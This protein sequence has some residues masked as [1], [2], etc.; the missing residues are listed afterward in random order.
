MKNK[1]TWKLM[2]TMSCIW[3]EN[4]IILRFLNFIQIIIFFVLLLD[5]CRKYIQ[6]K[7][8]NSL[9]KSWIL[10][11]NNK[12]FIRFWN[13]SNIFRQFRNNKIAK[14]FIFCSWFYSFFP[15]SIHCLVTLEKVTLKRLS[16]CPLVACSKE[17]SP[18]KSITASWLLVNI[19]T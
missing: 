14:L 9:W 19:P 8:E 5:K 15:T 12:S 13:S 11:L 10:V 4:K 7:N 6:L 2:G 16:P 1:R 17:M 3:K 18:L